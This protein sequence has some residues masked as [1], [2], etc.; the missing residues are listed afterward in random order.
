MMECR[1]MS[2]SLMTLTRRCMAEDSLL[3]THSTQESINQV[4]KVIL[5]EL[6]KLVVYSIIHR[7]VLTVTCF[8]LYF[9]Q[10]FTDTCFILRTKRLIHL[11]KKI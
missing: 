7:T 8:I 2:V 5:I 3:G 11:N 10:R 1:R 6:I 9:E 4:V